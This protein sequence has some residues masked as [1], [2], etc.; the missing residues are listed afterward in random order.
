LLPAAED[1]IDVLYSLHT[2]D[3]LGPEESY[4]VK[5][6]LLTSESIHVDADVGDR[7]E[8]VESRI[9]EIFEGVDGI[10]LEDLEIRS[11]SEMSIAE[12]VTFDSWGFDDVSLEIDREPEID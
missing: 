4:R 10:D 8:R 11:A 3:E 5:I 1:I 6:V 9:E 12:S 7:C 2:E